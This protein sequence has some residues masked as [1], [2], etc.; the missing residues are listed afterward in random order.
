MRTQNSAWL[1]KQWQLL[2]LGH[3]WPH[4]R[5][6]LQRQELRDPRERSAT[7]GQCIERV[8]VKE[9]RETDLVQQGQG[10]ENHRRTEAARHSSNVD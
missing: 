2:V 4:G 8:G 6:L 5:C 9:Q 7:L 1:Q 3:G 10:R